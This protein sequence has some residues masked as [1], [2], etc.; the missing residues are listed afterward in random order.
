MRD[1]LAT[2]FAG[3]SH[4]FASLSSNNRSQRVEDVNLPQ[5]RCIGKTDVAPAGEHACEYRH[6]PWPEPVTIPAGWELRPDLTFVDRQKYIDG[7]LGGED[8][9]PPDPNDSGAGNIVTSSLFWPINENVSE[10]ARNLPKQLVYTMYD[11]VTTES[12]TDVM[13]VGD[14]YDPDPTWYP[15]GTYAG[16]A[17]NGFGLRGERKCALRGIRGDARQ[18]SVPNPA[19]C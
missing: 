15:G 6:H 8:T 3:M 11:E 7:E 17:R 2:L 12:D 14:E 4:H 9:Y 5:L 10:D 16:I 13:T 1:G 18:S 19:R